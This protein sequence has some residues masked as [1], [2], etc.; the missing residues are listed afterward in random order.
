MP[1]LNLTENPLPLTGGL[2]HVDRFQ[3][4]QGSLHLIPMYFN[5]SNM[6]LR[7]W[8][9]QLKNDRKLEMHAMMERG[10]GSYINGVLFRETRP[11]LNLGNV[12]SLIHSEKYHSGAGKNPRS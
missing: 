4:T 8:M 1:D 11:M 2:P 3:S 6:T 7:T 9:I 10:L 12:Q 5:T